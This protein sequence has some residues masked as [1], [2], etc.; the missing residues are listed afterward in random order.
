MEGT[1]PDEFANVAKLAYS[2]AVCLLISDVGPRTAL[3]ASSVC[4]VDAAGRWWRKTDRNGARG[5]AELLRMG[6][7]SPVHCKS[8]PAQDV[9][10]LLAARKQLLVK[11][12]D[13]ELC[14]R[15]LLR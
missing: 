8:R 2:L 9:R 14:L 5:I 4:A 1:G 10:A 15:S 6:W 12:V 7:Y 13:V 11:T 3:E